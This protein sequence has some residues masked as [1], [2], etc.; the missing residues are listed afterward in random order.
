[1][2]RELG[3]EDAL[4]YPLQRALVRSLSNVA[5]PVGRSELVP[6]WAGQSAGLGRGEPASAFLARLEAELGALAAS[7]VAW[8]ETR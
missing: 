3:S 1:L 8:R 4:P 2:L 7:V 5:E 6:M